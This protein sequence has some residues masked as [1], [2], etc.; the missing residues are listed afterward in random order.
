MREPAKGNEPMKILI[1]ADGSKYTVIA[2]Q[3][4]VD[5]VSWFAKMPEMHVVHV[6]PPIPYPRAAAIA[7]KA[8]VLDW[9]REESEAAL[10]IAELGLDEARIPYRSAWRVGEV[11]TELAAYAKANAIDLVVM[12]SHGKGA[13]ANLALGSVATRCVATLEVPIMIVRGTPAPAAARAAPMAMA[14]QA[15][16]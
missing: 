6:Q 16:Q 4:L 9:Q 7:G 10:A 8:A 15:T 1:A 14:S 3:H 2:V 12:G 11:A 13:L 5:H